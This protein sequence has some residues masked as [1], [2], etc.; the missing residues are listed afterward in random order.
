M[1]KKKKKYRKER[2]T[3]DKCKK[4]WIKYRNSADKDE[5]MKG[6]VQRSLRCFV[7]IVE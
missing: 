7:K 1:W 2:K 3:T 5:M 4:T 6:N